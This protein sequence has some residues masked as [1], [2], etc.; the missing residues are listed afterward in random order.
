M[1]TLKMMAKTAALPPADFKLSSIIDILTAEQ[2]K[3]EEAAR[4]NPMLAFWNQIK[5]GLTGDGS[6]AYWEAA[7]GTGLPGGQNGVDKFKGKLVSATP[8]NKPKE[9]MIA[10]GGDAPDA[11]LILDEA[12]PGTMEPGGEISFSGTAKEFSKDPYMLTFDVYPE[13]I[14]GWTGKGPPPA[15]SKKKAAAKKKQ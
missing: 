5:A 8:E 15:P 6:A 1:T 11:K 12:L 7:E 3:Q 4:E 9:L 10:I 2:K 13:D 14:E